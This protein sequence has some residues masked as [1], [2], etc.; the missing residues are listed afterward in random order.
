MIRALAATL[1]WLVLTCGIAMAAKT[2]S[3]KPPVPVE[4]PMRVF[5]VKSAEAGCEPHCPEWIAAQG[6]ID[7]GAVARFKTVLKQLGA[8]KLPVLIHSGGGDM[9]ASFAIGR[10]LRK[11]GL[12]VAVARTAFI[13][14]AAG[15]AGCRR[16]KAKTNVKTAAYGLPDEAFAVCG[17]AC[18]FVLAAGARRFVGPTAF[19]GVHQIMLM[20][21][22]N[23]VLRTYQVT[24]K[25]SASG[26][27]RVQKK[28][29][30]TKIV[31][32]KIVP[33]KAPQSTYARVERYFA[34][35]GVTR[36][37]MPMLQDT[38]HAAVRWLTHD[39]LRATGI[40]THRMNAAQLIAGMTMSGD[41]WSRPAGEGA[42]VPSPPTECQY[43]SGI[44]MGCTQ[45]L[46]PQ[47]ADWSTQAPDSERTAPAR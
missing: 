14:C 37:I 16:N 23:K 41:G 20:Q 1:P 9:D 5:I 45:L 42:S 38:P 35:M 7:R 15:D 17:S 3:R 11:N 44:G 4:P 47:D 13:P 26:R 43:F 39:E 24:V 32:Q 6:K 19:V 46:P 33:K 29:I 8:R 40:A 10:L 28:L 25:P 31:S 2:P 34:E 12:D 18:A 30:A 21:T 27:P 36:Q 22:Y